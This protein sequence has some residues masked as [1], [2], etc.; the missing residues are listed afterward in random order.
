MIRTEVR[1]GYR[2]HIGVCFSF[3]ISGGAIMV[4][5]GDILGT[6]NLILKKV[7]D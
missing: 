7:R 5:P 6:E 2:T 4:D 3:I 1:A